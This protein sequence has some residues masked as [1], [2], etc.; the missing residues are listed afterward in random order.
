MSRKMPKIELYALH[1]MM[2]NEF[3]GVKEFTEKESKKHVANRLE[4][5]MQRKKRRIFMNS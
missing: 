4:G 2:N 1:D 3:L 5:K